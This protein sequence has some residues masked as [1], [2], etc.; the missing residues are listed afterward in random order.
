[1]LTSR[2]LGVLRPA[3]MRRPMRK[4]SGDAA[5]AA[6]E[7]DRWEKYSYLAIAISGTYGLYISYVEWQHFKHPHPVHKPEMTHLKIR[8]KEYP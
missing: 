7:M 3:V 1:M 4:M 6:I 2:L 5:E 8:A